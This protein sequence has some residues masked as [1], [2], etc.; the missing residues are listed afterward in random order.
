MTAVY[1]CCLRRLPLTAVYDCC[2]R[3]LSLTAAV[4]ELY[5][6]ATAKV[7]ALRIPPDSDGINPC[8][9]TRSEKTAVK[10]CDL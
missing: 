3:R 2:L 6:V 9:H 1:D 5:N 7:C 4:V 10:S 8:I